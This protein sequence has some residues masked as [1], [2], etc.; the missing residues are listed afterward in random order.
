MDETSQKMKN[1]LFISILLGYFSISFA[2]VG[3]LNVFYEGKAGIYPIRVIIRPPGVVPGLAE[4]TVRSLGKGVEKVTV[5]PVKW[6]AG[7]EGSPPPDVAMHVSG[8]ETL[9]HSELWLMDFGSYSVNVDVYGE[10]G[11]GRSI[12]PVNSIATRKLEMSLFLKGALIGLMV[13]LFSGGITIVGAAVRQSTL[14][15]GSKTSKERAKKSRISMLGGT[16]IFIGLLYGGRMWWTNIDN[17]YQENLFKPIEVTSEVIIKD[18]TRILQISITD[19]KW[20]KGLY[21]PLIPDHGKMMHT[22]FI[23]IPELD[24]FSHIHPVSI[25][26]NQ[27]TF[28]VIVP[29]LPGGNYVL[30]VDITHENGFAQ[31]LVDTVF[32]PEFSGIEYLENLNIG[33]DSDDSWMMGSSLSKLGLDSVVRVSDLVNKNYLLEWVNLPDRIIVGEEVKLSFQVTNIAG[34]HLSLEPYMGMLSHAGILKTDGSVFLHL[35]PIGSIS[36]ASQQQFEQQAGIKTQL[37]SKH[38]GHMDH[39]EHIGDEMHKMSQTVSYPPIE[40]PQPGQYRIWIQVKVSGEVLTG[41][42][43]LYVHPRIVS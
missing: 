10:Q 23:R 5:Q 32:V 8:D 17:E 30:F 22:Y 11:H 6:D 35:H 1:K 28:Q 43:N 16:L 14:E 3:S 41:I 12:V 7:P 15:S 9:F 24:A 27:N 38:E 33:R 34:G 4:I 13:F 19:E 39:S 20:I 29:P 36:M 42:F 2:H 37:R 18:D 40:F 25:D 31:T 21:P 26:K